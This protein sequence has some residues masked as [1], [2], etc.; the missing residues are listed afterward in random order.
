[1]Q[2]SVYTRGQEQNLRLS[3]RG[4]PPRTKTPLRDGP[5]LEPWR[6][7]ERKHKPFAPTVA[8]ERWGAVGTTERIA[9]TASAVAATTVT[10]PIVASQ[11]LEACKQR[12]RARLMD[13]QKRP[14]PRDSLATCDGGDASHG[15][16]DKIHK[17][18]EHPLCEHDV[19][20]AKLRGM[21]RKALSNGSMTQKQNHVQQLADQKGAKRRE[22]LASEMQL[23]PAKTYRTVGGA[24][25]S[26][27]RWQLPVASP[28]GAALRGLPDNGDASNNTPL[29]GVERNV[30]IET[31]VLEPRK[32]RRLHYKS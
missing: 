30:E 3:Q 27:D 2:G 1:M 5:F 32:R 7:G 28:T 6:G 29:E 24:S 8:R 20:V 14:C 21:P 16:R 9:T 25:S 13:Q 31:D 11:R 4:R 12:V 19:G 22:V 10:G 18:D 26:G 17:R 23:P 15:Q